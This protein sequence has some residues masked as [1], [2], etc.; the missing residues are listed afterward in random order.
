MQRVPGASVRAMADAKTGAA[1]AQ[2]LDTDMVDLHFQLPRS[3]KRWLEEA[4]QARAMS[5]GALVRQCIRDL[6]IR[7]REESP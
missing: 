7:R 2:E 4:A 3:W 5:V 6:M 1:M